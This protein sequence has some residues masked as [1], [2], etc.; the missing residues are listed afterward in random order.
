[1]ARKAKTIKQEVE[2]EV[3]KVRRKYHLWFI[4][5]ILVLLLGTIFYHF[6]E[7]WAW[8]DSLYFSVSTLTTVGYGDLAPTTTVSKIF[9][10]FYIFIG[11]GIVFGFIMEIIKK[12]RRR[13][14]K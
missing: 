1:M 8:M 7:S 3:R 9:T 6:A 10:I 4:I 14:D 13:L 12:E 11:L 2:K 5:V